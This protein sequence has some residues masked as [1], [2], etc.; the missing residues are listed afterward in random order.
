LR[1]VDFR[2]S[3]GSIFRMR[4][5]SL[6]NVFCAAA[7]ALFLLSGLAGC[8]GSEEA[9]GS[10]PLSRAQ[11]IKR[12]SAVCF[13]EEERKTKAMESASKLGKNFLGGSKKELAELVST[14]VLPLYAEMIEEFA[15]LKP[16]AKEQAMWDAIVRQYEKALKEAEAT[17][18]KQITDDSLASVNIA[19]EK[20]GIEE[21]TL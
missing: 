13:S 15:A 1:R 2:K 10:E 9:S 16:P 11:F 17:P 4:G 3:F 6:I 12:A 19:A 7:V 18:A 8:G 14:V 5:A 20:Y 21:C